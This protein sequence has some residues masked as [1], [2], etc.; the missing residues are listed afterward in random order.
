MRLSLILNIRKA[1]EWSAVA[2][3]SERGRAD[4]YEAQIRAAKELDG[5]LDRLTMSA[6]VVIG[7]NCGDERGYM[8]EGRKL[9][10]GGDALDIAAA[11]LEGKQLCANNQPGA[12]TAVAVAPRGTIMPAIAGTHF[13]KIAV[14]PAVD[15]TM[16]G[17]DRTPEQNIRA[18]AT[19]L[20]KPVSEVCVVILDRPRHAELIEQVRQ[21]GA[22]LKLIYDGD[23][24]AA[25]ACAIPG[26]GA[27]IYLG[28]GGA[29]EGVIAGCALKAVDG[30][31]ECAYDPVDEAERAL[32]EARG[33][34][35]G[36][37]LTMDD[38]VRTNDVHFVATGVTD[39]ELLK[40]VKDKHSTVTTESVLVTSADKA[41]CFVRT[42]FG[43][44]T[45]DYDASPG[46]HDSIF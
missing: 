20:N 34:R 5:L 11:P 9:G 13:D 25:L 27:D 46:L 23:I 31:F 39:G 33:V 26:T 2:A 1:C 40:G 15:P 28:T 45:F 24:Q 12:L 19:C 6:T 17:L 43:S 4:A 37:I 32:L 3:A 29:Q 35:I 42:I 10:R 8:C 22:R 44:R 41:T 38:I 36:D 7:D 21:A 16:V 30:F 18:V 14:G